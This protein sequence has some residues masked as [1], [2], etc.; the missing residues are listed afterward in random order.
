MTEENKL[1]GR[2]WTDVG[3]F[4]SYELAK[5]KVSKINSDDMQTKIR[6]KSDGTYLVKCRK[7][8]IEVEEKKHGKGKR[9]NKKAPSG[10]KFDPTSI[11][12]EV[13]SPS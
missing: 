10:G 4:E 11:V 6:R 2:P 8:T 12:R 3:F 13:P 7:T 5:E 9:R 1:F